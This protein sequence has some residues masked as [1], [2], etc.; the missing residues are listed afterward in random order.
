[1]Q[2]FCDWA[3]VSTVVFFRTRTNGHIYDL[4]ISVLWNFEF[5][6][7][8]FARAYFWGRKVL[9][10][11]FVYSVIFFSPQKNC[12]IFDI[13]P[14]PQFF[15]FQLYAYVTICCFPHLG[16]CLCLESNRFSSCIRVGSCFLIQNKYLN[17]FC[18]CKIL[19]AYILTSLVILITLLS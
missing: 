3:C 18:P 17:C 8:N 14:Y 2:Y 16:L 5:W 11:S 12:L 15:L 4:N 9:S 19:R 1:M 13:L 10:V 6:C 7:H